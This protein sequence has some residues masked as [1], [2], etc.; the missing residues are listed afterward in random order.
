MSQSK[1]I[2]IGAVGGPALVQSRVSESETHAHTT[3]TQ[4]VLGKKKMVDDGSMQP[5]D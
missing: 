4:T 3:T 1:A 5:S 2:K